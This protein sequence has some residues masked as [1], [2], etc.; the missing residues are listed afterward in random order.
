MSI[1]GIFLFLIFLVLFLFAALFLYQSG[2]KTQFIDGTSPPKLTNAE[3]QQSLAVNAYLP[4][5]AWGAFAPNTTS[6]GN[7]LA[8]SAV[9]SQFT[10]VPPSYND[11]NGGTARG[12]IPSSQ[13]CVDPDQI[14][15]QAGSHECILNN[16][17]SAGSGCYLTVKTMIDGIPLYPGAKVNI[18]VVEGGTGASPFYVPCNYPN[19]GTQPVNPNNSGTAFC[20]GSIGLI[21]PNFTP[22]SDLQNQYSIC[23]GNDDRT[24]NYCIAADPFKGQ[25]RSQ[26]MYTKLNDCDLGQF[27][28]MFRVTRFSVDSNY[29]ITQDDKGN[30]ASIV[31]RDNGYYLAPNLQFDSIANTYLF[32][33][34]ISN[35]AN[36][37]D[38]KKP[39]VDLILINPD[40]DTTRNG[41]YWLLQNQ[42]MNP[43]YDPASIPPQQ[44]YGCNV[45]ATTTPPKKSC[46]VN[47]IPTF[48]DNAP[49]IA[50]APVSPQQII[51]IPDILK[52]PLNSQADPWGFWTYLGNQFS[53]SQYK[54]TTGTF[55]IPGL[56][57]FR[58]KIPVT[59]LSNPVGVTVEEYSS[60]SFPIYQNNPYIDTQFLDYTN[61]PNAMV[62]G[63][64]PLSA[65]CAATNVSNNFGSVIYNPFVNANLPLISTAISSN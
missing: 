17:G 31:F 44:Y 60:G 33:N 8:Y 61:M 46:N 48:Y 36:S 57:P 22:L 28:Q 42:T 62:T 47:G 9:A 54:L 20:G 51:Y 39:I 25:N 27:E 43:Q 11:L 34:L 1:T 18:G 12:Y 45:G 32:S 23:K 37:D 4:K 24:P 7:C 59:V 14:F 21:A 5:P 53:I 50:F 3:K 55:P 56:E 58:T 19:N 26:F 38:Q 30:L 63:I 10:P 13:T 52:F 41:V 16:S 6:N 65:G 2:T 49:G 40:L 29:N 35:D 15:A 64:G